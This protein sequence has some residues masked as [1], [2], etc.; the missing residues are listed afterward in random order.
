MNNEIYMKYF[1]TV[2]LMRKNCL[3]V[4]KLFFMVSKLITIKIL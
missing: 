4:Q 2:H 1:T 3:H